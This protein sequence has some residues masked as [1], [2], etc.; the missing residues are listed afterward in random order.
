ME[1]KENTLYFAKVRNT[2]KIPA[3]EEEN[4][5]YDIYADFEGEE[6]VIGPHE[7]VGVPTGVASAMDS[8][9]YLQVEERGST[10][11]AGIKKSAGVVDASYRGEIF[12]AITNST[13][14]TLRI[15]KKTDKVEKSD[16]EILYPYT[17]AIAQLVLHRVHNEVATEEISFEDLKS[18]PSKRGAGA[19]GS[20]GK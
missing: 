6:L 12:I 9:W 15:T 17:K 10:G 20:S 18:I 13:N 3:R 2:A 16:S 19:L 1:A 11:I 5:G 8:N 14:K 4:A 7:T